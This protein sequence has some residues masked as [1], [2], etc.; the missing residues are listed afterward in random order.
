MRNA[1]VTKLAA[2]VSALGLS[3]PPH[4]WAL[5]WWEQRSFHDHYCNRC[6][7]PLAER[8]CPRPGFCTACWENRGFAAASIPSERVARRDERIAT[9]TEAAPT[10]AA[11][12]QAEA[13]AARGTDV[14]RN[15]MERARGAK[16]HAAPH[17]GPRSGFND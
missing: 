5:P 17:A 10:A 14:V 12:A 3:L 6:K 9:H 16:P 1:H 7:L 4:Y 2:R 11:L 8:D 13:V 15:I